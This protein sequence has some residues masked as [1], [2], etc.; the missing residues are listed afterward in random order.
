MKKEEKMKIINNITFIQKKSFRVYSINDL[1]GESRLIARDIMLRLIDE[2]ERITN[3]K[4]VILYENGLF[5]K[6]RAKV[7]S[8]DMSNII[9]EAE[10]IKLIADK[11]L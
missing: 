7:I 2:I 11:S 4:N 1:G 10:R 6:N 8:H 3:N 9:K 5:I